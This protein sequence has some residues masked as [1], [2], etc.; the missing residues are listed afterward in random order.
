MWLNTWFEAD[1]KLSI[2]GCRGSTATSSSFTKKYG[3]NTS[4]FEIKT[5]NHQFIFDA[6]SGFQNIEFSKNQV[7]YLLLSH[8]HHDHIQGL[9][10]NSQLFDIKNEVIVSSDLFDI[11]TV[12]TTVQEYFSPPYFPID[13]VS[14]LPNVKF[15]SFKDIQ[16]QLEAY[17]SLESI[18]LNHPGGSI[19]YKLKHKDKS[20]VYLCDN[21]FE[22]TQRKSL[23]TFSK[24]ADLLIWDGMFTEKELA[25]KKGWGH[26]S[27]KQ[28]IDFNA[29]ANC[30]KILISHHAPHRSDKE[31]DQIADNLPESFTL[32]SDGLEIEV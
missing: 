8:F 16:K 25:E 13:I 31:L 10:F 29:E 32:A 23:T 6:G 4:C 22:E 17:L 1:M 27:I 14:S 24:N 30:K 2:H 11:E 28:A 20:F 7:T 19:G 12:K 3:G 9:P 21:E 18:P 5:D 26:S 15:L